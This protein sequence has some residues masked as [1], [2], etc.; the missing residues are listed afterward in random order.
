MKSI[1]DNWEK[2]C[3]IYLNNSNKK[4]FKKRK[5]YLFNIFGKKKNLSTFIL[6]DVYRKKIFYISEWNC[7][8]FLKINSFEKVMYFTYEK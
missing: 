1:D 6:N 3:G 4:I 7:W 2:K 5:D 8:R